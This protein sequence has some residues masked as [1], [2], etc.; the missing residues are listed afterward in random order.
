MGQSGHSFTIGV[1]WC[2]CHM[3]S[4]H[5]SVYEASCSERFIHDKSVANVNIFVD[6]PEVDWRANK[7]RWQEEIL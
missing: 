7:R 1:S 5:S 3:I 6:R 2:Q 4:C